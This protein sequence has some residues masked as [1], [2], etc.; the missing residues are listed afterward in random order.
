MTLK[1]AKNHG[2]QFRHFE[3]LS[4]ICELSNV[5]ASLFY[6]TLYIALCCSYLLTTVL[7]V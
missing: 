5:V 7:S 1:Y 6:T 3:D 2:N 4:R